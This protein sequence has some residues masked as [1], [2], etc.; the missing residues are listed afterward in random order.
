MHGSLTKA[1]KV[2]DHTPKV[3]PQYMLS[4]FLFHLPIEID[5]CAWCNLQ[6]VKTLSLCVFIFMCFVLLQVAQTANGK[7]P[8]GRFKKRL[9]F[10][11]CFA[12]VDAGGVCGSLRLGRP[13]KQKAQGANAN[14][15]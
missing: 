12:A 5:V 8:T 10:R 6:F 15:L 7:K 9:Q 1:G 2:R 4:I 11:R 13:N 14:L 3:C